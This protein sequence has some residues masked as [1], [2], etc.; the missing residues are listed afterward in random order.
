MCGEQAFMQDKINKATV[1]SDYDGNAFVGCRQS[2]GRRKLPFYNTGTSGRSNGPPFQA[3]QLRVCISIQ[4]Q[5]REDVYQK[6]DKAFVNRIA[7]LPTS[8]TVA[9][10]LCRNEAFDNCGRSLGKWICSKFP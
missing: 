3:L 2:S 9:I 4:Q 8:T 10:V 5:R 6:R 7:C 1:T